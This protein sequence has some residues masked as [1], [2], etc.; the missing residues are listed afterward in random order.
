VSD[1]IW[2]WRRQ[3]AMIS[4]LYFLETKQTQHSSWQRWCKGNY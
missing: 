4:A 3:N 2:Y 1:Q